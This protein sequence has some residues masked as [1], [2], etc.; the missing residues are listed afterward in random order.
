MTDAIVD[1]AD[2]TVIQIDRASD[3]TM[4]VNIA[5]SAVSVIGGP[6]PGNG[7]GGNLNPIVDWFTGTGPPPDALI[8][9]G[10][11]D[12]YVDILTGTLYQLR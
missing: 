10:P 9:A 12:M 6:D 2:V 1:D 8:G 11:G 5:D 7:S 4:V 3:A